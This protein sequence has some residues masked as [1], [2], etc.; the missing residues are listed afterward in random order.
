MLKQKLKKLFLKWV[1]LRILPNNVGEFLGLVHAVAYMKKTNDT[2]PIYTGSKIV[3]SW[4]KNKK[5]RTKLEQNNDNEDSFKLMERAIIWL[6]SNE[7]TNEI[8]KWETK[9]WGEIPADFGRK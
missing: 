9:A 3:M 1:P 8:I 7:I 4:V 2:K 6:K 5:Q